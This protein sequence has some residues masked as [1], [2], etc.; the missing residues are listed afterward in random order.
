MTRVRQVGGVIAPVSVKLSR[1][2]QGYRTYSVK[3]LIE[4]PTFE[5]PYTAINTPGLPLP[6]SVWQFRGEVDIWCWCRP[7]A[8][9]AAHNI[10]EG[11]PV[12]VWALTMKF[13]DKPPAIKRCF[14]EH[15]DNPLLEPP[16]VSGGF[17]KFT[18]E[19]VYDRF[20][21]RIVTSSHEQIRGQQNEWD[22]GRSQVVIEQNV[23]SLQLGLVEGMKH[24][25]NRA[26]LWGLPARTIKLSDFNFDEKWWGVCV[27]YWT[28]KLTF[29]VDVRTWD[30]NLL[31]E[32]TK[33]LNGHWDATDRT[34]VLDPIAGVPPN[35]LNPAHFI[36]FKDYNGENCKVILNKALPAG[37]RLRSAVTTLVAT[38]LIANDA[39]LTIAAQPPK[40]GRITVTVV[41]AN[42]SIKYGVVRLAGFDARQNPLAE[43][44]EI[45]PGSASYVS[46]YTFAE[47]LTTVG[48]AGHTNKMFGFSGN[49]SNDMVT[50][51]D[52][53][54]VAQAGF[55]HVEKY[56]ESDFLQL[57]IPVTFG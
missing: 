26:P 9:L 22:A 14:E 28:R 40:P 54:N 50:I 5:G 45:G 12:S 6:G 15:F 44:V 52:T 7:D 4:D 2:E 20:G 36:H 46:T 1:D 47:L 31:D 23:P 27:K 30:R 8:E 37:A 53:P 41:D 10:P 33:V 25:V 38:T 56:D 17:S 51:T 43:D 35:P 55:I 11:E 48:D 16:K 57:G 39:E 29:E 3:Y 49:D 18:E 42:R 24:H 19:G 34:W 13:S 32:G 21:N